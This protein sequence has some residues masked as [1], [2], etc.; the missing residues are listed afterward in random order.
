MPDEIKTD[1]QLPKDNFI[2]SKTFNKFKGYYGSWRH[3]S[4]YS[5]TYSNMDVSIGISP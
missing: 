5:K 4:S 2:N 1:I 3:C